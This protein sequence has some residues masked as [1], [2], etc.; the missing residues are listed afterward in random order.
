MRW[1]FRF[2][3]QLCTLE[4]FTCNVS[5]LFLF[6]LLL[7]FVVYQ[8]QPVQCLLD[9]SHLQPYSW[10]SEYNFRGKGICNDKCCLCLDPYSVIENIVFATSSVNKEYYSS[11]SFS[12]FYTDC[13]ILTSKWSSYAGCFRRKKTQHLQAFE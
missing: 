9:E 7:R 6:S 13:S 4:F 3:F 8:M 1:L 5:V 11:R 12:K 2:F 10:G